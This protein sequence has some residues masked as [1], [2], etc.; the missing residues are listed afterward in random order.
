[1]WSKIFW[2]ASNE[3]S[4]RI[5]WLLFPYVIVS[6]S[7][8]NWIHSI[9]GPSAEQFKHS[10][11]F[12]GSNHSR[13]LLSLLRLAAY[14]SEIAVSQIKATRRPNNSNW[15]RLPDLS[16]LPIMSTRRPGRTMTAGDLIKQPLPDLSIGPRHT[17]S[18]ALQDDFFVAGLREWTILREMFAPPAKIKFGIGDEMSCVT[19][20]WGYAV[21][22]TSF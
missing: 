20:Q 1:M 12:S 17:V 9:L 10:L 13:T 3:T 18:S 6:T 7:R 21:A 2:R 14:D 4:R 22:F 15:I 16:K 8:S 5:I 19:P 11:S